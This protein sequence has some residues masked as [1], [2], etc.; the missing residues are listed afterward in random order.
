MLIRKFL[1]IPI[2]VI[3]HRI[4]NSIHS[5][6]SVSIPSHLLRF[7][8]NELSVRLRTSIH[9]KPLLNPKD[10][11]GGET[12]LS[13]LTSAEGIVGEGELEGENT[14]MY[15]DFDS[16]PRE[17]NYDKDP[18]LADILNSCVK[19]PQKGRARVISLFISLNDVVIFI[20]SSCCYFCVQN[21][22]KL[23]FSIK[24]LLPFQVLW[25]DLAC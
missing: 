7:K 12:D 23:V 20:E 14:E 5:S 22:L 2:I 25:S 1:A 11:G 3:P 8:A 4:S 10:K 21:A 16:N 24:S 15:L 6:T 13:H 9:A 19:D 17:E 18:E